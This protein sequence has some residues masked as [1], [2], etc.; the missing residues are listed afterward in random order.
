MDRKFQIL[1]VT[2]LL[3]LL[4]GYGVVRKAAANFNGKENDAPEVT[5]TAG[6]GQQA[7][8]AEGDALLADFLNE[9][10]GKKS[11]YAE[12]K[13][14]LP[15]AKDLKGAVVSAVAGLGGA[16]WRDGLTRKEQA[17]RLAEV[18]VRVLHWMKQNPVEAMGF[19]LNDPA[20]EAAGIPEL[21][22]KHVLIEIATENG[23]LNS[24]GWLARNEVT[25]GTL[26]AVAL[27]EMRAGG[28]FALYEKLA[29]AIWRSPGRD[30]FL[31]VPRGA[32]GLGKSGGRWRAVSPAG[33]RGHPLRGKGPLA[34]D[35]EADAGNGGSSGPALGLRR[36]ERPGGGVGARDFE[37]RRV[38]SRAAPR[39][40]G[41]FEPRGSR[42]RR[43]GHGAAAGNP[44]GVS[45]LRGP[46]A[47][48]VG[49]GTGG[50][51]CRASVGKRPRLAV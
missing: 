17:A 20:C 15:V 14:T 25:F 51:G 2:H 10:T 8:S 12:L 23:V 45:G 7:S 41:G 1:L 11:R 35:G 47:A 26:C 30:E 31:R 6:R 37:K 44:E 32:D 50:R 40:P 33:R 22:N 29:V 43:A 36:I 21:L 42:S 46:V 39:I 49:G 19:V 38:E 27:N 9:R 16:D 13:E 18:E 34:G 24:V 28:G 5:K 3:A 48:G 4:L